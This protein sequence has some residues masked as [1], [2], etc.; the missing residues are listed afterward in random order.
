MEF[1]PSQKVNS[2]KVLAFSVMPFPIFWT[3]R[4]D[5]LLGKKKRIRK[6]ATWKKEAS[7]KS[8]KCM[9]MDLDSAFLYKDDV[10]AKVKS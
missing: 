8:L 7:K 10:Q 2:D 1:S 6:K 9:G 3:L 5:R 4:N